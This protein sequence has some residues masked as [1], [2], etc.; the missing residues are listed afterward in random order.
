MLVSWPFAGW[1]QY[2]MVLVFGLM[3][4]SVITGICFVFVFILGLGL[5]LNFGGNL[6]TFCLLLETPHCVEEV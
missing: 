4:A 3:D 5:G 6:L 1:H 2:S